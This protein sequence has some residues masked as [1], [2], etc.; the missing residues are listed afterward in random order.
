MRSEYD[1]SKGVRGRYLSRLSRGCNVVLLDADVAAIYRDSKSVN[2][3]L[4]K[5]AGLPR[6]AKRPAVA[7]QRKGRGGD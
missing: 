5:L 7:R 4:R 3:A 2:L 1:F 6:P